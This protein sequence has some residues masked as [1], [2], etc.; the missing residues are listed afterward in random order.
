MASLGRIV[1]TFKPPNSRAEAQKDL[2]PVTP[3]RPGPGDPSRGLPGVDEA[4]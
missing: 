2:G 3:D 4:G 1:T